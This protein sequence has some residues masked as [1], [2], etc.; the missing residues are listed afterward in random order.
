MVEAPARRKTL[1]EIMEIIRS[2][3]VWLNMLFSYW[4]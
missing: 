2:L 4:V 3:E 1:A